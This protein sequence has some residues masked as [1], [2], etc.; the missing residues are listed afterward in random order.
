MGGGEPGVHFFEY[1]LGY[2][3]TKEGFVFQITFA[4][5]KKRRRFQR[6]PPPL[7]QSPH[8]KT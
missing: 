6:T 7:V 1:F 2:T 8:Y 5:S 3:V 4:F